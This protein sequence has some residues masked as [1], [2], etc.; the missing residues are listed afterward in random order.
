[1]SNL[2]AIPIAVSRCAIPAMGIA[3][4]SDKGP[5]NPL[6]PSYEFF[7]RSV[8]RRLPHLHPPK[9]PRR[10]PFS[11]SASRTVQRCHSI[12]HSTTTPIPLTGSHQPLAQVRARLD[13]LTAPSPHPPLRQPIRCHPLH[14]RLGLIPGSVSGRRS[15]P[16]PP[17]PRHGP[18][19]SS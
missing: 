18:R 19:R 17:G 3:A 4:K 8:R 1:L 16:A 6:N 2:G 9:A 14:G 13:H 12:R 7:P 15:R 10:E 11:F 5:I